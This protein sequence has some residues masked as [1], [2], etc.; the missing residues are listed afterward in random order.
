MSSMR[1]LTLV[2]GCNL[3][4]LPWVSGRKDTYA[5]P[6]PAFIACCSCLTMRSASSS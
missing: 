1:F 5:L 6:P 2:A 3:S 4:L